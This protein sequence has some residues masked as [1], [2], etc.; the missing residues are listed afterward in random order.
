MSAI[1]KKVVVLVEMDRFINN[2]RSSR[3]RHERSCRRKMGGY[4][5]DLVDTPRISR[6]LYTIL[7]SVH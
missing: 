6:V 3:G 7:R 2:S 5:E 1:S 4:I